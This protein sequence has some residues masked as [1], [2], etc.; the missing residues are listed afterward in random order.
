MLT[1]MMFRQAGRLI[2][3]RY[4]LPV[5]A[6]AHSDLRHST[7]SVFCLDDRVHGS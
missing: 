4:C 5:T 3:V 1:A 6:D 2:P 7:D